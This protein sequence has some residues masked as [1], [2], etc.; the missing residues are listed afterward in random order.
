MT[1]AILFLQVIERLGKFHTVLEPGIHLLIPG[2]RQNA[3]SEFENLCVH[4]QLTF[5]L[6]QV[7]RVA[8]VWHLKET[9]IPLPGQSAITKDNVAITIDGVLYCKARD[10]LVET[11]TFCSPLSFK[12]MRDLINI[13]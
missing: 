9:A 13:L 7:D 12:H 5:L 6:S 2:V 8:Y 10:P 1:R 3:S 4:P 11:C